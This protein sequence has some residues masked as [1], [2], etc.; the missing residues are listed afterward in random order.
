M[1]HFDAGN[2]GD[3]WARGP[4]RGMGCATTQRPGTLVEFLLAQQALLPHTA[5]WSSV[6][7]HGWP[8]R[9]EG[10]WSVVHSEFDCGLGTK[11]VMLIATA[12]FGAS[13]AVAGYSPTFLVSGEQLLYNMD[14]VRTDDYG[15]AVAM[16]ADRIIVGEPGGVGA[17]YNSGNAEIFVW[18]DNVEYY[19][20][21]ES[22]GTLLTSSECPDFSSFGFAVDIDGDYAVVGAPT[23][24]A[25]G[26]V[27]LFERVGS[28]WSLNSSYTWGTGAQFGYA[29]DIDGLFVTIGAPGI[30]NAATYIIVPG[31]NG[32]ALDFIEELG[33]RQRGVATRF[34]HS[35]DA[36]GATVL[37]GA[38]LDS[39]GGVYCG[40]VSAYWRDSKTGVS[41]L[42]AVLE[43]DAEWVQYSARF[44][45][46]V[47]A[48]G[49]TAAV[50]IMFPE[51]I[52]PSGPAVAVF[53]RSGM[54]ADGDWVLATTLRESSTLAAD[55]LGASVALHDDLLVAG[56]PGAGPN[57]PNSGAAL[58]YRYSPSSNQWVFETQLV[59]TLTEG[60]DSYGGTVAVDSRGISVGAIYQDE[61]G[62]GETP[63]P[64]AVYFYDTADDGNWIFD[65]R[66]DHPCLPSEQF[67]E[68]AG[69]ASGTDSYGSAVAIDG[70][71]L[72]VGDP[73]GFDQDG[74]ASGAVKLFTRSTSDDDW[75]VDP[76]NPIHSPWSTTVGD[77]FGASVAINGSLAVVGAPGQDFAYGK[78]WI[79][80][81]ITGTWTPTQLLVGQNLSEDRLG[82][83]VAIEWSGSDAYIAIG[84]PGTLSD[85]TVGGSVNVY[86][87]DSASGLAT[88]YWTLTE[89]GFISDTSAFGQTVDLELR[90]DGS[91]TVAVGNPWYASQAYGCVE[92]HTCWDWGVA[93]SWSV[94][95]ERL[96]PANEDLVP[97][98]VEWS[99]YVGSSLDLD[100][101]RLII[102]AP[103]SVGYRDRQGAAFIYDSIEVSPSF[104]DWSLESCLISP[105]PET[106][107]YFGTSVSLSG[108]RA[109]CGVPGSDYMNANAGIIQ[110]FQQ[111]GTDWI[112]SM[113]LVSTDS[114]SN[115]GLGAS[116]AVDN[117]TLIAGVPGYDSYT[118]AGD[119]PHALTFD[120]SIVSPYIIS[121]W[122]SL[123][124]DFA[125]PVNPNG[126]GNVLFSNLLADPYYVAF[127][128]D[129]WNGSMSVKLDDV[130][131]DLQSSDRIITGSVDV[132]GPPAVRSA[133]FGV[134]GGSL[135]VQDNITVGSD[136]EVGQLAFDVYSI[137]EVGDKL[138]L[139]DNATLS[140][141]LDT[142][143]PT[144]SRLVTYNEPPT[145]GGGV[146]VEFGPNNIPTDFAQGDRFTLMTAGIGPTDGLFDVIVLPGLTE[147]LAFQVSYGAPGGR[148]VGGCPVGE[149]A[150]CFGNCCP[151]TW[152][153]DGYCDDGAYSWN[154]EA[155]YLNCDSLGCDGGDCPTC[156]ND[157]GDWEMA[158]EVVSIAGLLNFGGPNSTTVTGDPTGVEVVD[159]TGDGAEEICVT[160]AGA[161]GSLVIFE[162]DGAGGI[163]QQIIIPT[164]DEPLDISSGDF[165]GD[166]R[167]DLVVA[168][169]L[170]QDVT[171]YYNDDND[172]TNGFVEFDL[173]VDGPPTCIAGINA[174]FDLYGDIV[175]GLEDTDSDGNGYYAIYLGVA[176]LRNLP[177][178]RSLPGGPASGGGIAPSGTPLGVDPSEDEDQKDFMF[179]GRQSDGKTAVVKGTGA[180]RGVTLSITEHV[181]GAYPGGLTIGDVSG[182]GNS[183]ICVTS[184]TNGT[185]AILL[186]DSTN[187]G[188]FLAPIFVPIGDVPTRITSVDFDNDGKMDLAA[189]VED[190]NPISGLVE[191][192]VRI[193]Q[194][195]GSLSFTS[196]ETAWGED[197]VLVASGDV[198]GDSVNELVT[199]GGGAA[200]RSGAAEPLLTLRETT[201]PSC[202]GDF[203]GTGDVGIDDLLI[204]LSEFAE[205]TIGC[206]S[207]IDDDGD[208]DIDDMLSLI[209]AWG[210]CPR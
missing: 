152:L 162:N 85:T 14:G 2:Q 10:A 182:D 41:T 104:W 53:T 46:S 49:S 78:T 18:D 181:T 106:Y 113:S 34:G 5:R 192:V 200:F 164:G 73:D 178:G 31:V 201:T 171:I 28:T 39:V 170:S 129:T 179:G 75:V 43:P 72:L 202:P 40:S 67:L 110:Q 117:G 173:D 207:D 204:L 126:Y 65:T 22:L 196:I 120:V 19:K 13:P 55:R 37:I 115:D 122:G 35:V 198:S 124:S 169:N 197:A 174:N 21:E 118:D 27:F 33:P 108:T 24:P 60:S 161:P 79:F 70:N 3:G 209:G 100:D 148:S 7:Q 114:Q 15:D 38:P 44:G 135:R 145:L 208:V 58:V 157:A 97:W 193:L 107:S 109:F 167:N 189:I 103:I 54:P 116:L 158:I 184:T 102:G 16:D 119:R 20:L 105:D 131:F 188:D 154:G 26:R 138:T 185:V 88:L 81:N 125:W 63:D 165:D 205:C 155:I 6:A 139:T 133:R 128:L 190:V 166:G 146:R 199:I 84:A 99:R 93:W 8:G 90:S 57:G 77:R 132:G 61:L 51:A 123:T 141:T 175:V 17:N 29:V 183:D 98:S 194:G 25:G 12:A 64:G 47:T 89:P 111:S 147:G 23:D 66:E 137:L 168:N 130:M 4:R 160:L 176:P 71:T 121:P 59:G 210:P 52:D 195:N 144:V 186:Q 101:G 191:P 177:G 149:I 32:A 143:F 68:N 48:Y 87:W 83:S 156:W 187:P 1:G 151:D 92:I 80:Q 159:L 11:L 180:L 142:N 86:K 134:S 127:D 163:S 74:L 9:E 30:D 136:A 140:I 45:E 56:A 69:L 172:V 91:L 62:G 94:L 42:E 50:G 150:D 153:G 203:D 76:T 82:T 112:Y 36:H 206:Q 96:I 95:E